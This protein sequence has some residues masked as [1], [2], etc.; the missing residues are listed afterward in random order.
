MVVDYLCGYNQANLLETNVHVKRQR[1]PRVADGWDA[2]LAVRGRN[3]G[4]HLHCVGSRVV[5]H[6]RATQK[7][8]Q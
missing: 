2:E 6:L 3:T 5:S 1:L 4:D 8:G 7:Q